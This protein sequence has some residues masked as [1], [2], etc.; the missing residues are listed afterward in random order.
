MS[1][2]IVPSGKVQESKH[3]YRRT[4]GVIDQD[5]AYF[6]TLSVKKPPPPMNLR[7]TLF[8]LVCLCAASGFAQDSLFYTNG[9]VIVG[10]VEEVGLDQ[11]KYRTKSDG[12]QVLVV[13]N[14]NDLS[15]V[16][17]NGGQAFNFAD[18]GTDGPSAAFMAR[19]NAL[20]FD[21]IAPALNHITIGYEHVLGPQL[22]F[23]AKVGYIGLWEP[24]R[25]DD[26][27]NSKGG[28]ISAGVK[29]K[30][31]RSPK[32]MT[33]TKDA[34][35]LA[36]WYLRPELMFSAWKRT[37]YNYGFYDP[38]NSYYPY[39]PITN[40]TNYNSGALI[41]SIGRELFLG[42]HVTFDIS[43]GLGYGVQ[44]RDGSLADGN[45]YNSNYYRQEY[46]YTHAFFGNTTPLVVSGALRFG[47]AF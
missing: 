21:V 2:G 27:Y 16:K 5:V 41:L 32:R 39:G 23:V 12:N 36:G 34:H 37:N 46:N 35:P 44:W 25:Y 17:L 19:K 10:Q 4:T 20:S 26:V 31:P 8:A 24:N 1:G 6:P 13:V 14:K 29:F 45:I 18:T 33:P 3:N 11:I 22:C 47:Y 43:G 30:L 40:S 9:T 38:F 28:L 42:E 15:R 7:T